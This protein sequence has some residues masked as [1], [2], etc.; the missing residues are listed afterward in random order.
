MTSSQPPR[1]VSEPDVRSPRAGALKQGAIGVFGAAIMAIA[2]I[3]PLTTMSSNLSMSL[4]LGVG[5]ATVL[6]ILLTVLVFLFFTA[7]YV[8]LGRYVVDSGAYSAYVAHGLGRTAGSAIAVIATLGYNLAVVAFSGVAGYFLDSAFEPL[9]LDLSWWLYALFVVALTGVLGY[10]GADVASK[11]TILICGTQFLLL[12]AFVVAVLL[13]SPSGFRLDV[14]TPSGLTGGAFGLSIVFVLLS[15]ASFE[16]TAAYGEETRD[17]H[18]TVPRAT[19]LALFLLTGLFIA[20]TWA[21]VAGMNGAP[22]EVAQAGP[23]EI[24]PALFGFYLG[25][26]TST[27]LKFVIAISII[28]AAI[29]FHNLA[30]RYMFSSAR[31]GLFWSALGRTNSRRQT[32]HNAVLCQLLITIV[33][34]APFVVV[35]A[36]PMVGLL[37][38]IAGYNSL[39]MITKMGTSSVSVIAAS[40]RGRITGSLYATR[41]APVLAT[42]GFLTAGSLIV[43]HYSQVTESD[44]A[45]VNWMPLLLVVCAAYGALRH[46]HLHRRHQTGQEVPEP[47]T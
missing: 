1:T 13:R 43:G 19:Y 22:R 35:G 47:A 6:V 37:P 17:P 3:S 15:L 14:F 33:F 8:V 30:T 38:A 5:P 7:G 45:W 39:S 34:L 41:I 32:P 23:G 29:A 44:A 16:T 27:P 12:G 36:D 24:V 25:S 26:W 46:Q 10:L 31:S 28:G 21:V 4:V 9:G 40:V 2:A 20:G 18:R 42:L 11:V